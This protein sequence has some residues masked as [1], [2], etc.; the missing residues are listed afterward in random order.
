[1]P[2]ALRMLVPVLVLVLQAGVALAQDSLVGTW[3]GVMMTPWGQPMGTETIFFPDGTY[4]TASRMENLQTRHWGRYEIVQNWVHF[5]IQG[6]VPREFCGTQRCTPLAWPNSE[7][8]ALTRFDGNVLETSN[9][10]ME[11]VR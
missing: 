2:A 3:R 6:A 11:R 8:W 9:G 10:R 1:M 7:T 4:S 5:Y